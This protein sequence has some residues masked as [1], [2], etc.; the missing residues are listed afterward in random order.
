MQ[1]YGSEP[2]IV[3]RQIGLG[4]RSTPATIVG[5]LPAN[6]K[7]FEYI[8]RG[9]PGI[10]ITPEGGFPQGRAYRNNRVPVLVIARLAPGVSVRQAQA[11]M[12]DLYAR[13]EPVPPPGRFLQF[14]IVPFAAY[15]YGDLERRLYWI[16]AAALLLVAIACANVSSLVLTRAFSTRQETAIHLALGAS[17]YGLAA[18]TF[19]ETLLLT[20]A[21]GGLGVVLGVWLVGAIDYWFGISLSIPRL[22]EAGLSIF[23]LAIV[24]AIG[25]LVGAVAASPACLLMLRWSSK[26]Q[27][28]ESALK[29]Q[30]LEGRISVAPP[31]QIFLVLQVSLSTLL[32]LGSAWLGANLQKLRTS[33]LG[34][35]YSGLL[36][37]NTTILHT[38]G[39]TNEAQFGTFFQQ[40]IECIER[41]PGC[42]VGQRQPQCFLAM[43]ATS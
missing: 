30:A 28:L 8:G 4:P 10:L 16:M 9:Q 1:R 14:R 29:G 37:L 38:S 31:R 13:V 18:W 39:F 22:D 12:N 26:R 35:R 33:S 27:D 17:G 36:T 7:F 15:L 42:Q 32:V 24:L 20:M 6:F 3:G 40:A 2:H 23:T 43:K 21:G 25:T 19:M 11:A 34:Y 41:L 5:A